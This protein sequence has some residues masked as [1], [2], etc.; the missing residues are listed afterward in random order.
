MTLVDTLTAEH[1]ELDHLR[2]AFLGAVRR[3]DL[4]GVMRAR[5]ATCR[6]LLDHLAHEDDELYA[7]M[8]AAGGIA[9]TLARQ[10]QEEMGTIGERFH[11]FVEA[12]TGGRIAADWDGFTEE[13][14]SLMAVLSRRMTAEETR[15]YPLLARTAQRFAA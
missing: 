5:A 2:R 7:G 8:I 11:G 1:C 14:E 13:A 3:R 9:G 12:W 15:L 4:D 6:A 10:F